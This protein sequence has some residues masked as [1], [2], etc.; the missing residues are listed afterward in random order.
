MASRLQKLAFLLT[1]QD[2]IHLRHA[3]EILG[4]SEMTIRRDIS[5]HSSPFRVLGGYIVRQDPKNYYDV[6]E[7]Q[8]K[9]MSEKLLLG[10]R[11]A[12]LIKQGEVVF[13]DCGSTIPFI[14]SQIEPTLCFTALCCS[15]NTLTL[16]ADNPNCRLI[17]LGGEFSRNNALFQPLD[18]ENE[19]DLLCTDKAFISAAGFSQE[20]GV[21]C[22]N[23]IEAKLKRKAITKTKQAILVADK[24][25]KDVVQSAFVCPL[26]VFDQIITNE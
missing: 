22:F 19:L 13:F 15:L 1:Q 25:K 21:T 24:A 26:S 18:N 16:L 14:A 4:V 20:K 23:F 5:R 2:Q 12:K 9:Q 7:Q 6:A 8:T 11:A 3:A 17:L 10:E